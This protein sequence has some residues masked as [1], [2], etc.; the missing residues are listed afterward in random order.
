MVDMTL[1]ILGVFSTMLGLGVVVTIYFSRLWKIPIVI[2][3]YQGDGRRPM[4]HFTKG[5]LAKRGYINGLLVKGYRLA[6][7][8]FK[9]AHYY[10]TSKGKLGALI[11]WEFKPGWL[12]PIK[13]F[14]KE[15]E[16]LSAEAQVVYDKL[17]EL[18]SEG[19]VADF[20]FDKDAYNDLLL[21]VVDDT[22][23]EWYLQQVERIETQYSGGW[24]EF[25]SKYGGHLVLALIAV[26]M[27][28]GAIVW[29]DK[30]P[31]LSAQCIKAGESIANENML[32][33]LG[34]NLVPP[35]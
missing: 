33:S 22:D 7:R 28:V 12:T 14:I 25:L 20:V 10:P 5:R 8:D 18:T 4:V 34:E 19:Q 3:R 15:N 1:I 11:L 21:K 35:G 6:I 17:R 9:R 29:F 31:E 30:M 23:M 2:L 16:K 32:R 24:R 13:P 27:L 26:L